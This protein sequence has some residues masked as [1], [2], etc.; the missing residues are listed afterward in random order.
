MYITFLGTGSAFAIENYQ[1]NYVLHS[2]EKRLLIDAGDDLR[3]SLAKQGMTYKDITDVYISHLHGDHTSGLEYLALNSYYDPTK[4]KINLYGNHRVLDDLWNNVLQG[5]LKSV[6][7]ARIGLKDYFN[8]HPIQENGSFTWEDNICTL[9]QSVHI[10]DGFSIVSSYG[11]MIT[12]NTINQKLFF[13]IDTQFNPNQIKDFYN[14]ADFIIQDCEC[15]YRDGKPS[16]SSVHAH[17][18]EIK[19]LPK[20]ITIKM[21][22]THYQ[23]VVINDPRFRK[24]AKE[25]GAQ[26]IEQQITVDVLDLI[27]GNLPKWQ[28][29]RTGDKVET[30]FLNFNLKE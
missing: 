3:R 7:G 18:E 21:G 24:E 20:E 4:E 27:H 8:I 6:V 22:L 19:T 12:I 16:M 26:F 29:N 11:L 25:I 2:N 14:M 17:F 23:D 1:S 30:F 13:T 28:G 5:R 9:V 15:T 10:M